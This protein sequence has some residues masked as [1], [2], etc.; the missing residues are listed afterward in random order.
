MLSKHVSSAGS[1]KDQYI[2]NVALK[3]NIKIGGTTNYVDRPLSDKL[4]MYVGID[5]THPAPGSLAPSVAAIVASTDK[6][7]TIYNTYLR[8]QPHRAEY[9]I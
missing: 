5:V 9:I 6:N 1:I 3:A 7:C 4:T 2:A 8:T